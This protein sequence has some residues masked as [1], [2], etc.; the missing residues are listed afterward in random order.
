MPPVTPADDALL[1]AAKTL[2]PDKSIERVET[3]AKY[4]FTLVGT[5]GTLLTGFSLFTT[6]HAFSRQPDLL[7]L[8][9]SFVCGSLALAMVAM[10]P[11]PSSVDRDNLAEVRS[12]LNARLLLRGIA[13]VLAGL[14]FAAALVSVTFVGGRPAPGAATD[15]STTLTVV[16]GEKGD[17]VKASIKVKALPAGA[18][19]EIEATAL[20]AAGT[21]RLLTR[22]T[23]LQHGGEAAFDLSVPG[24]A[25]TT[26]LLV[27]TTAKV[28]NGIVYSDAATIAVEPR[29]AAPAPTRAPAR[30]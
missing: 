25:G 11:W 20:T 5:V 24:I 13:V 27:K 16:R 4:L 22:R 23:T 21:R 7:R 29:P 17:D 26:E 9:L 19:V 18:E 6:N 14:L 1:D 12:F 30:R 2:S 15:G 28:R 3:H 8:P 10:T